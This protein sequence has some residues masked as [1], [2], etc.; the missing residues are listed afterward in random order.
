LPFSGAGL[1]NPTLAPQ[2]G[3]IIEQQV[4]RTFI[5]LIALRRP[6]S[7]TQVEGQQRKD[8]HRRAVCCS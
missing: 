1:K 6:L 4:G 5:W 3:T 7:L 8:G 2:C